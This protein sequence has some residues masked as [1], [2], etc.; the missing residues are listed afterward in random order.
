MMMMIPRQ[1]VNTSEV[2][3]QSATEAKTPNNQDGDDDDDDDDT[4][5]HDLEGDDDEATE[6]TTLEERGSGPS[7]VGNY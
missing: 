2:T 4:I 1:Q 3:S 7:K 5:G 6:T